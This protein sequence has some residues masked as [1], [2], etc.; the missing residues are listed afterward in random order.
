MLAVGLVGGSIVGL[1][2]LGHAVSSASATAP[3]ALI[4]WL[5]DDYAAP[6]LRLLGTPDPRP[7]EVAATIRYSLLATIALGVLLAAVAARTLA[8][9]RDRLGHR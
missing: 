2:Q 3:S 7:A 4:H 5:A 1:L 9:P 8:T 6:L